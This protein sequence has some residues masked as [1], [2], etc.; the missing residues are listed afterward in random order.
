MRPGTQ[1]KSA[2]L[3]ICCKHL[4]G[5]RLDMHPNGP[6]RCVWAVARMCVHLLTGVYRAQ[7]GVSDRQATTAGR[8]VELCA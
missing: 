1:T 5:K 3:W 2:L 8:R 4:D 6:H 7:K